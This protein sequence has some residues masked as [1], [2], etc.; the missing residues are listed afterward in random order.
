MLELEIDEGNL[1]NHQLLLRISRHEEL[2]KKLCKLVPY[3]VK[4]F[5][6]LYGK[7]RKMNPY[8]MEEF[9]N[10]IHRELSMIGRRKPE[11][12]TTLHAM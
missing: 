2:K 3:N 5:C 11:E 7:M 6:A 12:L 10:N 8:T 1:L 4:L 9:R